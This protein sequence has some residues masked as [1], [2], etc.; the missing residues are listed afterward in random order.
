MESLN[1]DDGEIRA[2]LEQSR[3]GSSLYKLIQLDK[4][5]DDPQ[6]FWKGGAIFPRLMDEWED[7]DFAQEHSVMHQLLQNRENQ[8]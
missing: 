1:A 2:S 8:M 5:R 4:R 7:S 3:E 6:A